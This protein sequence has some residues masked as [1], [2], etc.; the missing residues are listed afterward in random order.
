M[1]HTLHT[2]VA[3]VVRILVTCS[4]K[5]AELA[6]DKICEDP[7][8]V[9][10]LL[11]ACGL[12]TAAVAQGGRLIV[13]GNAVVPSV[14]ITGVVMAASGALAAKRFCGAVVQQST[15]GIDD[16]MKGLLAPR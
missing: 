2:R 10:L 12:S 16:A 13:A 3:D 11:T 14:T 7:E 8:A 15:R 1:E 5:D 9:A 4:S 6:A